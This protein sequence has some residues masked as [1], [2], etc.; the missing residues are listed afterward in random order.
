MTAK[1]ST[2]LTI[3]NKPVSI[4]T[5]AAA[6]TTTTM[7]TTTTTTATATTTTTRHKAGRRNGRI[8]FRT[9]SS[10]ELRPVVGERPNKGI[11]TVLTLEDS[12]RQADE[13]RRK[14]ELVK[15]KAKEASKP[16]FRKK[17]MRLWSSSRLTMLSS[18]NLGEEQQQQSPMLEE[19]KAGAFSRQHSTVGNSETT[20]DSNELPRSRKSVTFRN[21]LIREYHIRV[22][23]HPGVSKGPAVGITSEFD[24]FEPVSVDDYEEAHPERLRPR[25]L[26]MTMAD[27][28]ELLKHAGVSPAEIQEAQKRSTIARINR[29]KTVYFLKNEAK[30]EKRE[31]TREKLR[32]KRG[33]WLRKIF[34]RRGPLTEEEQQDELWDEA[35]HA[36]IS[37]RTQ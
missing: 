3:K 35:Q 11:L 8:Y 21:V 7:T 12:I 13:N 14:L 10:I 22:D 30:E 9:T 2:T 28:L 26:K 29:R 6:T 15:A 31:E 27:R 1:T 20:A 25:D 36:D 24:Q 32:R 16:S 19:G 37:P 34:G 18:R 17:L 4:K 33:K 5:T 23:E